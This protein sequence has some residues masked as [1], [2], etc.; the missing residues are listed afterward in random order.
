MVEGDSHLTMIHRDQVREGSVTS[1]TPAD[2]LGHVHLSA[3]RYKKY[4]MLFDQLGLAE[5]VAR[6]D[7]G[8]WFDAESPSYFNGDTAKGYIYARSDPGMVV[9]D[10]DSYVPA[11]TVNARRPG[12]IVFK[13]VSGNW[14][15]YKS[16][17][18]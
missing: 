3:E 6:S 4:L 2:D 10:L 12:F 15:L 13:H 18:Q 16:S 9:G 14:Y 17:N 11:P 7:R 5:G 1:A 8:I